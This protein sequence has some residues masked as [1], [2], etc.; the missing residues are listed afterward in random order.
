MVSLNQQFQTKLKLNPLTWETFKKIYP[1]TFKFSDPELKLT[2]T[3]NVGM[4]LG[5]NLDYLES[6]PQKD[7]AD[8]DTVYAQFRNNQHSTKIIINPSPEYEPSATTVYTIDKDSGQIHRL[9]D[10]KLLPNKLDYKFRLTNERTEG[11]DFIIPK[12]KIDV[13]FE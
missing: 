13:K 4:K 9:F 10:N 5:A 8:Y 3:N 1:E 7:E 2:A 11:V 6:L 12:P